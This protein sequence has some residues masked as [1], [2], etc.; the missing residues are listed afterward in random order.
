VAQ[1]AKRG[2]WLAE[3]RVKPRSIFVEEAIQLALESRWQEALAVNQALIER[4]GPDEDTYNRIGKALTELG[5]LDEALEAYKAALQLNP[6][7]LIAQKNV[8]KLSAMVESKETLTGAKQAINVDVFAEE[9]GKTALTVLKPPAQTVTVKVAPGDAVELR[10]DGA[11][12]IAETARGVVLGEV[13]PKLSRRLIPFID[14]GNRYSA[15]VARVDDQEIEVI[16]REVFQSQAN[17]GKSSFP[18]TRARRDEFRPY[19]KS[20]ILS[21]RG[22]DEEGADGEEDEAFTGDGAEPG[23]DLE[24]MG[25]STFQAEGE[26][27]EAE[28]DGDDD[29]DEDARPEDEY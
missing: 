16:I 7:N 15:A 13:E 9:P 24:E 18:L 2:T 3:E 26:G 12:L 17:V 23:E 6:L 1:G 11:Q 25:M 8:R 19:T 14:S 29:S 21:T 4:H 27:A 28:A 5:R 22:I 10:R 20:S